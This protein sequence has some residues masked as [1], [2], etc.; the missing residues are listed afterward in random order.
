MNWD[1]DL[2]S[3]RGSWRRQAS[4]LRVKGMPERVI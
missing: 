1:G 3:L 4:M 2:P